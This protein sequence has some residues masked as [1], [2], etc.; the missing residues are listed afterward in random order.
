MNLPKF[1]I[2]LFEPA[3]EQWTARFYAVQPREK[4]KSL[5]DGSWDG[6]VASLSSETCWEWIPIDMLNSP[7]EDASAPFG[8]RPFGAA[9][10]GLA[11]GVAQA[12]ALEA[13]PTLFGSGIGIVVK[14]CQ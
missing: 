1:K 7:D 6:S 9:N 14:R 11:V 12:C 4:V 2:D 8:Q 5:W 3:A 13:F 10:L